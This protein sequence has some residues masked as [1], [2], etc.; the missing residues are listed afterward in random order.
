MDHENNIEWLTG[1]DTATVTLHQ[2]RYV[3]KVR[4]LA[5]KYPDRVMV[6]A[7]NDDGSILA[8]L[9]LKAIRIGIIESGLTDE[10]KAA[11][12]ERLKAMRERKARDEDGKGI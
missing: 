12:G 3:H 8:H 5:E 2:P 10:Q 1:Q 11:A 7:E 4:A 6:D 9:P